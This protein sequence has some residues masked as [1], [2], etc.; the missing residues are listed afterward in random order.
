[1]DRIKT[2][3]IN[4]L[5]E[6]GQNLLHKAVLAGKGKQV[7]KLLDCGA[8]ETKR[9]LW[10]A[11]A[12]DLATYL[13]LP[14][15]Q[16]PKEEAKG[17]SFYDKEGNYKNVLP[18]NTQEVFGFSYV[19][20]LRFRKA[21]ELF[22]LACGFFKMENEE[23]RTNGK[24][25]LENEVEEPEH[26]LSIRWIDETFGYGCFAEREYRPG[27]LVGEYT[28]L[29][30]PESSCDP[31][32]LYHFEYVQGWYIDAQK[33]G[34]WMRFINHGEPNVNAIYAIYKGVGHILF[35]AWKHIEKGQQLFYNYGERYWEGAEAL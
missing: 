30:M 18:K 10:G 20:Q 22:K 7:Q 16:R 13:S 3:D 17:V 32:N 34:N 21:S 15:F 23:Y 27:Q 12:K 2:K 28:G 9:N 1:M 19:H 6:Q 24:A 25:Y 11:S 8:Q 31:D 4:A 14:F 33:F 35:I 26:D 29:V 5:D